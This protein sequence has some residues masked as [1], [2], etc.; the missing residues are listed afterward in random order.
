MASPPEVVKKNLA[1]RLL[2]LTA[3]VVGFVMFFAL[4]L[5][6]HITFETLA[7]NRTELIALVDAHPM[8]APLAYVVGYILL[9]AL[10]LPG[11]AVFTVTGG[12]LFG[13]IAGA[14]YSMIGATI[15]A[16]VLFLAAR[17]ALGDGLR[18][19]AGGAVKRMEEGFRR[20]ALSYLFILRLI[21][22][23]PFFLVNL[24]P[25]FLGVGL[26]TFVAATLAGMIPGSLVYASVGSGL[27][28]VFDAGQT[29][30][31]GLLLTP[32]ILLPICGLVVL[33]LIPVAY[34]RWRK[35]P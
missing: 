5:H 20:D 18:A 32:P 29:P 3:L 9:A 13:T 4:G 25:A 24:V 14:F 12:F 19:R 26:G 21:P 15:G 33:A 31:L 8:L 23:F 30:D 6:R 7:Q 11:A 1:L 17:T 16:T 2:P 35:A 22:L 34:K 10:S 27:G 28:A